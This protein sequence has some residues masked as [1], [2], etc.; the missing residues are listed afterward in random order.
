MI[1]STPSTSAALVSPPETKVRRSTRKNRWRSD[2]SS[3][4]PKAKRQR[5]EPAL[6]CVEVRG[7]EIKVR[8]GAGLG[9]F[10]RAKEAGGIAFI[11]GEKI[12]S[13][14]GCLA[15]RI[16]RENKKYMEWLYDNGRI[17]GLSQS[18]DVV[19]SSVNL[20]TTVQGG[21]CRVEVGTRPENLALFSNDSVTRQ[22]ANIHIKTN[23]V[24][25][26]D[27][28]HGVRFNLKECPIS[29]RMV[30]RR[31]IIDGQEL[32]WCYHTGTDEPSRYSTSF[33][34]PFD[35]AVDGEQ[36]EQVTRALIEDCD[37]MRSHFELIEDS[38]TFF[39]LRAKDLES[40][41]SVHCE[42]TPEE[43]FFC[44][45]MENTVGT[46][47]VLKQAKTNSVALS[48]YLK[49]RALK[50][51]EN[52]LSCF[53]TGIL[54][55]LNEAS[56]EMV[57]G[58]PLT[59]NSLTDFCI[60]INLF[61]P[62]SGS[63]HFPLH[64]LADKLRAE[65]ESY[66][67]QSLLQKYLRNELS[68]PNFDSHLLIS[69]L[70]RC[71][72][73]NARKNNQP[74][75]TIFDLINHTQYFGNVVRD[76]SAVAV[77]I[78][79]YKTAGTVS[80][81]NLVFM[82]AKCRFVNAILAILK[83]RLLDSGRHPL[84]QVSESFVKGGICIPLNKKFVEATE[85]HLVE[86]IRE[87]YPADALQMLPVDKLTESERLEGM[88]TKLGVKIAFGKNQRK[89]I[90]ETQDPVEKKCKLKAY[91]KATIDACPQGK[92]YPCLLKKIKGLG[93]IEGINEPYTA[94]SVVSLF[95]DDE[96]IDWLK[97]VYPVLLATDDELLNMLRTQSVD[98]KNVQA[99]LTKRI[100][101]NLDLLPQVIVDSK[102]VSTMPDNQFRYHFSQRLN[103]HGIKTKEGRCWTPELIK[104]VYQQKSSGETVFTDYQ[105]LSDEG[106]L[107]QLSSKERG[108]QKNFKDTF[109]LKI[110]HCEESSEKIRLIQRYLRI[111]YQDRKMRYPS[112][113]LSKIKGFEIPGFN[114]PYSA[115]TLVD[116][117]Q[118]SPDDHDWLRV[119]CPNQM[120]DN[121]MLLAE[122]MRKGGRETQEAKT[123]LLWRATNDRDLRMKVIVISRYWSKAETDSVF[124]K[125]MCKVFSGYQ[126]KPSEDQT[127][128]HDELLEFYQEAQDKHGELAGRCGNQNIQPA[129]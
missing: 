128:E 125:D 76:E 114:Q 5:R 94:E 55:S 54:S 8:D 18:P 17:H 121:E 63:G 21:E 69:R 112:C 106:W 38:L 108:V 14:E 66:I 96:N 98:T 19:W 105:E 129:E 42:F 81:I 31:D 60:H 45:L 107:K 34:Q 68:K 59:L 122:I 71:R 57:N 99:E 50:M 52:F 15:L 43:S 95:K 33:V 117:Y 101:G 61:D 111:I 91:L 11:K 77:A 100:A 9:A 85:E 51:K 124:I 74:E 20:W 30:A 44:E 13:V 29:Q 3:D 36:A 72:M 1:S 2:L 110:N 26:I 48:A 123:E 46:S 116:L 10:A 40:K 86:F 6:G 62:E 67:H 84:K 118:S 49:T 27:R 28:Q 113:L 4:S 35:T 37:S 64:W 23:Y 104:Q 109:L 70:A 126:Y 12:L 56:I 115:H 97:P 102:A 93:G 83:K 41:W 103:D 25:G 79:E 22:A 58:Q 89:G 80:S 88:A 120:N 53:H 73:P 47:K 32:L 39:H 90:I 24:Q 16:E 92:E 119:L 75:W 7:S 65:P 82:L 78:N 87:R 127:W